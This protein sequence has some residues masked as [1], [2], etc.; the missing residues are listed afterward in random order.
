MKRSHLVTIIIGVLILIAILTNPNQDRHKS[1]IK[2]KFYAIYQKSLKQNDTGDN[3]E[4]EQAGQAIG[5][6][7]GN[8]FIDGI[9]DNLVSTDNYIL[10][11]LTKITWDGNSKVVG[12]GVFG[13]VF[14]SSQLDKK[15]EE[16]L[17]NDS[18]K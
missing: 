1:A 10:F 2:N 12:M 6:A 3:N 4:W 17:L 14:I 11:S 9:I 15:L 13:N 7:F 5:M 18:S 16:N 8:I